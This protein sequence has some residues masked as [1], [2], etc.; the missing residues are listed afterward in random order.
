[1]IIFSFLPLCALLAGLD[2]PLLMLLGVSLVFALG[3]IIQRSLNRSRCPRCKE[4]FFVQVVT[5]KNWTPFSSLSF[6]PQRKCRHCG[7]GLYE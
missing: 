3:L 6:P 4:F 5:M 7:L 2:N 1:L